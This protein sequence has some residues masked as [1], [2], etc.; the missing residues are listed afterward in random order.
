MAPR[1][2]LRGVPTDR[3]C[4]ALNGC[5]A[6]PCRWQRCLAWS[7]ALRRH[8]VM[9]VILGVRAAQT[10]AALAVSALARAAGAHPARAMVGPRAGAI[11]RQPLL[12]IDPVAPSIVLTVT[13]LRASGVSPIG[14]SPI[15]PPHSALLQV[16]LRLALRARLTLSAGLV[17]QRRGVPLMLSPSAMPI[18]H[19]PVRRKVDP[20]GPQRV[21]LTAPRSAPP[22]G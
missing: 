5:S 6:V 3:A 13:V 14:R 9:R 4:L 15:V 21:V 20:I 22:A 17:V 1:S 12:T 16:G 18:A 19:L 10:G 11:A 2:R 8:A 7:R